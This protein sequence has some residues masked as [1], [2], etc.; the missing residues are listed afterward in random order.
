MTRIRIAG[1]FGEFELGAQEEGVTVSDFYLI[2][3]GEHDW[4]KK[5]IAGRIPGVSLNAHGKQQAEDLVCRLS[6][7]KFDV[8]YSSPLERAMQTADPVARSKGMEIVVAPEIIEL[9]FGEWSGATFDKLHADPRWAEWNKKRSI[10]RMPGGELMCEVQTRIV[11]FIDQVHREQKKGNFA[12]F[13][14]G[15]VIR[16]AICYWLGMPLDFIPRVEVDPAS[17]TILRIDEGGPHMLAVN[18]V[19]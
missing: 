9:D 10:V 1:R 4:L 7:V 3:H 13:G 5:G 19:A 11:A 17:V 8:I 14:H 12:L 16:S 15:D 2:R 6:D 18:R